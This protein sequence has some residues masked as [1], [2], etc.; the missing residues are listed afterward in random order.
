MGESRDAMILVVED[1]PAVRTLFAA[2]LRQEGHRVLEARN[3]AEALQLF[4]EAGTSIDLLVTDL[5]MPYVDGRE[6]A[7]T[8]VAR[9][10]G[11]RI[12][13][14]SGYA[15]DVELGPNTALLQKPFVRADLL[16][17]VRSLLGRPVQQ[18]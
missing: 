4:D 2:A 7:S 5:R 8:L 12:L 17:A 16:H 9:Q 11:L 1:E 3:G 14:V 15:S 6:L 13:F 18:T 10:P